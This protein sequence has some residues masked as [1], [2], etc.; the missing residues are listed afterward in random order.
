MAFWQ[1]FLYCVVACEEAGVPIPDDAEGD[2][3][4]GVEQ[5]DEQTPVTPGDWLQVSVGESSLD[6]S[7]PYTLDNVQLGEDGQVTFTVTNTGDAAVTLSGDDIGFSLAGDDASQFSLT[8]PENLSSLDPEESVEITLTFSPE[9]SST[10]MFT[11]DDLGP[12]AAEI[13]VKAEEDAE[14]YTLSISGLATG[15]FISVT[16]QEGDDT[17]VL[18]NGSEIAWG[19]VYPWESPVHRT[20]KITNDGNIPL[21]FTAISLSGDDAVDTAEPSEDPWRFHWQIEPERDALDPGTTRDIII[22]VDNPGSIGGSIEGTLQIYSL[23]LG[24][25]QQEIAIDLSATLYY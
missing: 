24:E 1:W 7:E 11:V 16:R 13:T 17:I 2:E 21:L 19:T 25:G 22:Q 4:G 8:V 23:A 3:P 18:L 15:A 12:R 9:G 10:E 20:V 5:P 6:L 14:A